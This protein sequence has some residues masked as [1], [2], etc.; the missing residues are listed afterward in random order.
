MEVHGYNHSRTLLH[1]QLAL[2][3]HPSGAKVANGD[4]LGEEALGSGGTGM[5]WEVPLPC[6]TLAFGSQARRMHP[7]C[8]RPKYQPHHWCHLT[9]AAMKALQTWLLAWTGSQG[10][11][12]CPPACKR[13]ERPPV[14]KASIWPCCCPVVLTEHPPGA[15]YNCRPQTF[16]AGWPLGLRWRP[17]LCPGG[18]QD[19]GVNRAT[20]RVLLLLYS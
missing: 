20:W 1:R 4:F 18:D 13:P 14:I 2:N 19:A 16:T 9:I 6:P 10:S 3:T 12:G 15:T 7:P 17:C 8:E 11:G 5:R